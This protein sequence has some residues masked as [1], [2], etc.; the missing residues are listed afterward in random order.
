MKQR[1]LLLLFIAFYC[2][3]H[4]QDSSTF[5]LKDY[6]Y[7]TPGYKALQLSLSSSG[8]QSEISFPNVNDKNS[9]FQIWP[10]RVEY[11]RVVSTERKQSNQN[12]TMQPYLSN[13]KSLANGITNK[14][15]ILQSNLYWSINQRHFKKDNW[16]IEWDNLLS[17]GYYT[18]KNKDPYI[19]RLSRQLSTGNQFSI[20]FGKGRIENVQDAQ[21]AMY[22]INDLRQHGLTNNID[23]NIINELAKLVTDL[24]NRRIFDQR[25]RR[26]YELTQIDQFL[27]EKGISDQTDIRHF[28]IINDNWTFAFNPL[29]RSGSSWSVNI[30]AGARFDYE[31]NETRNVNL[32]VND[33]R[34]ISFEFG[35][36][37][38][39]ERYIP[40]NLKWQK[41]MGAS[42]SGLWM[43]G[44]GEYESSNNGS[45]YSFKDTTHYLKS[46]LNI[47]YGMGFFPN[48]RTLMNADINL[49][50]SRDWGKD[51]NAGEVIT[52]IRPSLAFS[53]NYFLGY[54]TRLQAGFNISYERQF[55]KQ[56]NLADG[57]L[58]NKSFSLSLEHTIF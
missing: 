51:Q 31:G 6:K 8:G 25:R 55:I 26:I 10:S 29:R 11:Q 21:V 47:F 53:T 1:I 39:F 34:D 5:K 28:T 42:L 2:N 4:A 14:S 43:K 33:S 36:Q 52:I 12:L 24:N 56:N 46:R 45:L 13:N 44:I 17:G 41:N 16:F 19:K 35:P 37:V 9:Y 50:A 49:Q 15:S 22:I 23:G 48:N 58:F 18:S 38:N 32:Y 30:L 27:R 20:G 54:R 57:H 40:V 7:R 3:V